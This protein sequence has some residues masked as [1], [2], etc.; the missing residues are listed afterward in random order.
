MTAWVAPSASV[1]PARLPTTL[2]GGGT[3]VTAKRCSALPPTFVAVTVTVALPAATAVTATA[4]PSTATV[5]TAVS[6]DAT[7]YAIS[8][9]SK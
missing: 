7:V 9:P 3:T 2:G 5:A 1:T 8:S 4:A 6:E